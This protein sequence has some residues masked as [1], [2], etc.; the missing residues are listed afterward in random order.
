MF[1]KIRFRLTILSGSITTLILIAMTMCYLYVSEKTLMQSWVLS[2][3]NDISTIALNLEQQMMITPAWLAGLEGKGNYYIALFDDKRPF[4][5]N[6]SSH[7]E[8]ISWL[9]EKDWLY[10]CE[11]ESS[12]SE[13]ILSYRCLY[14]SFL[15]QDEQPYYCFVIQIAED[16]APLEML[17]LIPLSDV[18]SQ[19]F[20]QRLLFLVIIIAAF[21]FFWLFA[22]VFTGRLLYPI[23]E[24]RKKQNRFVASAS[25]ELR[26]PLAVILSCAEAALDILP[27]DNMPSETASDLQTDLS[28]IKKE[29]LRMSML[30][31]DM[32]SL[33]TKDTGHFSIQK[34]PT[35]LDTLVLNIC[36]TF[37]TMAHEKKLSLSTVLPEDALP[38]CTCD[39][40]R[41]GQVI[42]ILI[43]NA[44]SYTREGGITVSLFRQNH[45]FVLSVSDT[46]PGI[47]DEEKEKIFDRFYRTESSRTTKGHFGLGL[48]IA[49]EIIAAH[50]GT[51]QVTDTSEGGAT[52]TVLLP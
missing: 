30:L 47:P 36:E 32:L 25:H 8:D 16:N 13:N 14:K 49:H 23:E 48:S 51:I 15:F 42:S 52:F 44:I 28:V 4:L 7:S 39:R 45:R 9:L 11:N 33:I 46:G 35:Q 12:F 40:E 1:H 6:K 29:S 24:N 10:Y 37:E 50:Q 3:E 19:I 41:I 5:Y 20:R 31:E 2:L 26:T 27:A 38:P 43:H 18:K 17:F 21:F 34:V 22:W